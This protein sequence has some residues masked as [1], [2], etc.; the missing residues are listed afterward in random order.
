M[1][2]HGITYEI[3]IAPGPNEWVWIVHTPNIRQG[4]VK[5]ARER[6][7]YAAQK[8][9][10]EFCRKNPRHCEADESEPA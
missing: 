5:G 10:D 7:I 6:A 3:E 2:Y 4:S 8:T 1:K 9:I